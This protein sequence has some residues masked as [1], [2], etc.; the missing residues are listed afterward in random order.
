[1]SLTE[2]EPLPKLDDDLNCIIYT[3]RTGTLYQ[4]KIGGDETATRHQAVFVVK[5]MI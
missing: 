2:R 5:Q 4:H 3:T 1:M